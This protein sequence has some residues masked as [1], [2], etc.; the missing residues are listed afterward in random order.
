MKLATKQIRTML[1]GQTLKVTCDTASEWESAI[2]LAYREK[3]KLS[4]QGS[5]LSVSKSSKDLSVTITRH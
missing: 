5:E 3:K 1:S 4:A 2:R